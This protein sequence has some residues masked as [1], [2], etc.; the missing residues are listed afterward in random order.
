MADKLREDS[1]GYVY[2]SI[3]ATVVIVAFIY[4]SLGG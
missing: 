2:K 3:F 1:D 4:D